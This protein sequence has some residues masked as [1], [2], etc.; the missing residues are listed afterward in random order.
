MSRAE[1][2]ARL[3]SARLYLCTDAR[4]GPGDLEAFLD[5][6]LAGGV[7]VVQL[8]QKGM[9]AVDELKAL[10][11]VARACARHGALVAVNDR[12]D[13]AYAC[14]AD[15]LHLGQDDLPVQVAR[16][17][18][19]AD[20]LIGRS[21]HAATES[22]AAMSQDGVDYVA[23]GP[24]WPT[25][26]KPGRPAPGLGLV[27]HVVQQFGVAGRPWFAIGGIG[28]GTLSLVLA[29]GASRV[30]VVRALTQAADPQRA[31][32][33]LSEALRSAPT[34]AT[35]NDSAPNGSV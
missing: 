22:D 9:E 12:A 34:G 23:V 2:V 3:A 33:A 24:C 8:R 1:R 10:D 29:A 32:L 25:P 5:A 4:S 26:T 11:V 31:A 28:S 30:V 6:V 16:E 17:I 18:V 20:M 7:D 35:A 13:I 19:G 14:G 27:R 15:V 21:S